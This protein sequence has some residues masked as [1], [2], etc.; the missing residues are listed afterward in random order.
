M[1]LIV[2]VEEVAENDGLVII[3]KHFLNCTFHEAFKGVVQ[4]VLLTKWHLNYSLQHDL[5]GSELLDHVFAVEM[6]VLG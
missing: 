4:V 1:P 3:Q 2:V 6:G 5:N